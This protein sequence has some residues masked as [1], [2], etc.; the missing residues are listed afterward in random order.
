MV[1]TQQDIIDAT[2]GI[3]QGEAF[4]T[5]SFSIDTRSL[6][7]GDVYVALVGESMDGHRFID[8]AFRK[9]AVAVIAN[10]NGGHEKAQKQNIIFVEDT[11]L[12][13]TKMAIFHR[14]R[15]HA[16]AV[17]G[18][19]GSAGKT[20]TRAL[21]AKL[22]QT[23]GTVHAS[24]KSYNNHIGVPLTMVNCPLNVD[25]A[26]FEMGMNHAGEMRELSHIVHPTLS[27]ITNILPVHIGNFPN[28]AGIAH[29]KAEIFLGMQGKGTALLNGDQDWGRLL[30]S[31]A[32]EANVQQI[33]TFGYHAGNTAQIHE[34]RLSEEGAEFVVEIEGTR[35][36]VIT[37]MKAPHFAQSSALGILLLN[38]LGLA[39]SKAVPIFRE[40][41][42]VEGRGATF[43]IQVKGGAVHVI[44]E[45]YNANPASMEAA[46]K[47]FGAQQVGGQKRFVMGE[48]AEL[49]EHAQRYHLEM[50]QAIQNAGV[51][52]VYLCGA[53]TLVLR[54]AL[55]KLGIRVAHYGNVFDL[56]AALMPAL[57]PGDA[58]LIKG[59][60]SAGLHRIV[61]ALKITNNNIV[62]EGKKG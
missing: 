36:P 48:M 62:H 61:D 24:I 7:P 59:S 34:Y 22:L 23:Y 15:I 51:Q 9:G 12:A 35:Y 28:E 57:Q 30:K 40:F 53:E 26:L 47:L 8:E 60:N 27:I 14:G 1:W 33:K 55:E 5:T 56:E 11:L 44:D 46:L 6:Q 50:A 17:I 38:V 16:K 21:L 52:D 29:A 42:P 13:L 54:P 19:T 39:P 3:A 58:L 18:I 20:T 32:V 31:L 37:K 25:Y 49:G 2:Q 45:S 41:H 10:K 4:T 43:E